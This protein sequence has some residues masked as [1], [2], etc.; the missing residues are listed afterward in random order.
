MDTYIAPATIDNLFTFAG[1]A[2]RLG[3][4][5][6]ENI[7]VNVRDDP[8]FYSSEE[9]LAMVTGGYPE[10]TTGVQTQD[11]TGFGFVWRGLSLGTE[12]PA[13]NLT[14]GFTKNLEWRSTP[15]LGMASPPPKI[16]GP[17]KIP[18]LTRALQLVDPMFNNRLKD[19]SSTFGS[20]ISKAAQTGIA[21]GVKRGKRQAHSYVENLLL[22]A[23]KALPP[24]TLM[25]L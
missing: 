4:D 9:G 16:E 14:F 7:H 8:K 23:V 22:G 2:N 6:L 20:L 5:T 1:H 11:H 12:N 3:T 17:S 19:G 15:I 21:Y 24:A 25:L 10:L 13:A 18:L